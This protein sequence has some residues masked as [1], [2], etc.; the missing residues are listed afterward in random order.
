MGFFDGDE[1][2]PTPLPQA[3]GSKADTQTQ[4]TVPLRSA[5]PIS[6]APR[7]ELAVAAMLAARDAK[8]RMLAAAP[9]ELEAKRKIQMSS[10]AAVAASAAAAAAAAATINEIQVRRAE[11]AA[12]RPPESAEESV[13][14]ELLAEQVCAFPIPRAR[15]LLCAQLC[16]LSGHF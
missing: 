7:D 6:Y 3:A 14:R 16:A 12:P 2:T 15:K 4:Q 1:R 9:G 8:M 11:I 5:T 13:R 10:S